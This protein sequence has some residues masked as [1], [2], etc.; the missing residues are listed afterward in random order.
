MTA[1]AQLSRKRTYGRGSVYRY[2][3][4]TGFKYRW[5]LLV[6]VD[7]ENSRAEKR[8]V[9]KSGYESRAEAEDALLAALAKVKKNKPALSSKAE[10]SEVCGEWLAD[11]ELANSTV[12]GYGKIVNNHI[13]PHLG[14]VRIGDLRSRQVSQ[15][16]R[17]LRAGGRRD[18]KDFGGHL[19]AN[20]VNKVHIVL[21]AILQD[22]VSKGLIPDNPARDSGKVKPPTRR[23][24]LEEK[25]EEPLWTARQLRD[26]LSWDKQVKKDYLYPLW[27][28]L[29]MTGMRRGEVI[30]LRWGDVDFRKQSISIRRSADSVLAKA[31]KSTKTMS[32]R[33][34]AVDSATLSILSDYRSE[35][36][37]LSADFVAPDAYIFGTLNNELRSPNDLTARWARLLRAAETEIEDLPRV[38]LKGLRHTHATLMLQAG[39]NPKVVQERL[40]HSDIRTTLNIYSHVTPTIQQESLHRFVAWLD[41]PSD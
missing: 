11:L 16:Y 31:I 5:Q 36:S 28:L 15:F 1:A 4:K 19:S 17:D 14:H 21:G 20:T 8:R 13:I 18:S 39:E 24:I 37:E 23:Q 30:A 29:A 7:P 26:F 12:Y 22:A 2:R 33:V 6:P 35:R 32:S 34:I 41:A 10:I 25:P 9:S 3:S 40:G 38:T 27:V